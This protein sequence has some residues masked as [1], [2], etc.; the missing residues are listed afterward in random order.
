MPR[1]NKR[2]AAREVLH[3]S[4]QPSDGS[5]WTRDPDKRG[6]TFCHE[7]EH[8]RRKALLAFARRLSSS[9]TYGIYTSSTVRAFRRR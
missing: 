1:H 7:D 4:T 6:E 8:R 5:I 9:V 2:D 3:S